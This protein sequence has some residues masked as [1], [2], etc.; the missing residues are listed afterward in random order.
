MKI[1][2]LV[3]IIFS[4]SARGITMKKIILF[5]ILNIFVFFSTQV[6]RALDFENGEYF[7]KSSVNENYAIDLYN[8]DIR[9]ES[10]IQI[11]TLN[12]GSNQSWYINKESDGYYTIRSKI[13]TNKVFD[14]PNS[15]KVAGTNVQLFDINYNNNQK[16]EIVSLGDGYYSFVSKCNGLYL[17][18][19]SSN[20]N[21]ETNVII[22]SKKEDETQKF[23]LDVIYD[24]TIEDG[25]YIISSFANSNK[26]LDIYNNRFTNGTNIEL[27]EKNNGWNQIWK[28]EYLNNG[29]Y[30]IANAIEPDYV[31]DVYGAFNKPET[32]VELF[33]YNGGD[34]QQWA[35]VDLGNGSYKIISKMGN[36]VLDV[37]GGII[38]N[39]SNI[40]VYTENNGINQQF[41][42]EKVKEN[43]KTIEDG[44]Y[45]ITSSKNLNK[46][47]DVQG[48]IFTNKANID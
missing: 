18:V 28:I 47:L 24:K 42:F 41:R 22:D 19:A 5:I 26:V 14:I 27:F 45:L 25:N 38:S 12:K 35:I 16:W 10:N 7:I 36:V 31:L 32:N 20:I 4:S 13:N 48:G 11:Y 39:G 6:I 30:K 46:V 9:N 40:Q 37:Y 29:Y 8:F 33:T 1:N 43:K 17:T 34:N 3:R 2:S 15:S 44:N 21:N 23:K